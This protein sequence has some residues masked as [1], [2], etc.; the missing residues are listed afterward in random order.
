MLY[1]MSIEEK[2]RVIDLLTDLFER[3]KKISENEFMKSYAKDQMRNVLS[4]NI[5]VKET[6]SLIDPISMTTDESGIPCTVIERPP[7]FDIEVYIKQK[8]H[9]GLFFDSVTKQFFANVNGMI[10][11]GVVGKLVSRKSK[12]CM[13]CRSKNNAC[14]CPYYHIHDIEFVRGKHPSEIPNSDPDYVCRR[15]MHDMLVNYCLFERKK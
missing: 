9:S 4:E 15:M 5:H 6:P 10:L 14:D 12:K 8:P 2:I 1:T 3:L 7:D 13:K 11:K